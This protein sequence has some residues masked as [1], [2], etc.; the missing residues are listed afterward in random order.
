MT[1]RNWSLR[2]TI[3]SQ[4]ESRSERMMIKI[5]MMKEKGEIGREKG[6]PIGMPLADIKKSQSVKTTTKT[7]DDDEAQE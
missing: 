6:A 3:R 1:A 4:E 7:D 2:S 5:V